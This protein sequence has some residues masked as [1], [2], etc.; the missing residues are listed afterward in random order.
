LADPG[1]VAVLPDDSTP[2]RG[3]QRALTNFST[4]HTTCLAVIEEQAELSAWIELAD[5]SKE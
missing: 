4:R 2:H 1:F 5:L 3:W